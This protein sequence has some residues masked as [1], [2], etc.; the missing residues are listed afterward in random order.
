MDFNRDATETRFKANKKH[1]IILTNNITRKHQISLIIINWMK[2]R[3]RYKE[4]V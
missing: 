1:Q 4:Q 2:S 3:E